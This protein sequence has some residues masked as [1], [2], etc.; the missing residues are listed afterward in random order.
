VSTLSIIP[1]LGDERFVP[2]YVR[3]QDRIRTAIA[4]GTLAP[5]DRVWSEAE[6]ATEFR[7]T[8]STVRHALDRLVFEGLI[9]RHVG[10]GSFVAER[11][12]FHSPIDSRRCLSFEEQA[13][14]AGHVVSYRSPSFERVAAPQRVA[15]Q[16]G[17][18][19]GE[20]VFKFERI[21]V[22]AGRPVCVEIR[23]M[24]HAI[25]CRVTGDMLSSRPAHTFVGEILGER[26]P[27][28]VVSITAEIAGPR[29]ADLLEIPES[30]AVIV[31][32]N[33]HHS[34]A[35]TVVLCGRSIYAGDV[36][37]DYVLGR[38]P[39]HAVIGGA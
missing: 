11:G 30:A 29:I 15:Q 8:R 22:I 38:E 19:E 3:I 12:T 17:L 2:I 21:R 25:G 4:E 24:S 5:G 10:R 18:A 34:S 33:T 27:T 32:S 26:I 28:I 20:Q 31:R 39:S 6:L 13:A 36:S 37:T 9:V 1:A 16:L 7:T 23:Y 35:G 14:L